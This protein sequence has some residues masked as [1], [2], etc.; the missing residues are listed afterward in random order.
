MALSIAG[1]ELDDIV[2]P[3]SEEIWKNKIRPFWFCPDEPEKPMG[4]GDSG[5]ECGKCEIC[6]VYEEYKI[7]LK[8]PGTDL[9]HIF[10][11]RLNYLN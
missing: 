8:T 2:K 5:S 9:K 6:K 10:M 4:C 11:I 3:E 7:K 1:E